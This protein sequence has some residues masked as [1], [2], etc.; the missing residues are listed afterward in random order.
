M[1][2]VTRNLKRFEDSGWGLLVRYGLLLFIP[3]LMAG[4]WSTLDS[5]YIT[6][7]QIDEYVQTAHELRADDM[8]QL[9][10]RIEAARLEA[11][12]TDN[13]VRKLE[14]RL[15]RIETQNELLLQAIQELRG[16]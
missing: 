7:A 4:F 3:L 16:K 10:A 14:S 2:T 6:K 1:E 13:I 15:A 12:A 5:R 9:N 11:V 8:A